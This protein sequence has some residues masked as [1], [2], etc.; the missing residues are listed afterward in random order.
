MSS[1]SACEP[2]GREP[3]EWLPILQLGDDRWVGV[4]RGGE[5]FVGTR[6]SAKRRVDPDAPTGLLALLER[7]LAAVKAEID[8][9]QSTAG[10][11]RGIPSFLFPLDDI[12][13]HALKSGSDYWAD[14]ALAW[15]QEMPA[16]P[17]LLVALDGLAVARW[18]S[19]SVRHRARRLRRALD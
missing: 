15:V 18:A 14:L 6:S 2:I 1:T 8:E 16:S 19:Q 17:T 11:Q 9:W 5:V 3:S 10:S 4:T 13:L 12:V 7:P